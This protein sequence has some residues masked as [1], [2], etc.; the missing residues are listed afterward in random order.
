MSDQSS[1]GVEQSGKSGGDAAARGS[2]GASSG[3]YAGTSQWGASGAEADT[4]SHSGASAGAGGYAAG[5]DVTDQTSIGSIN[6]SS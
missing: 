4:H 6:V 1:A 5:G 2:A 3:A